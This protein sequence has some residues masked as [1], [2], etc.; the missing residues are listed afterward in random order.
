MKE[1][2]NLDKKLPAES[3]H[4]N[5]RVHG[6]QK[7]LDSC[8]NGPT[9]SR[10]EHKSWSISQKTENEATVKTNTKTVV[11]AEQPL[12][13]I[14]NRDL[15]AAKM[16]HS[17]C[18]KSKSEAFY[19]ADLRFGIHHQQ[20]ATVYTTHMPFR[21]AKAARG[22]AGSKNVLSHIDD[23]AGHSQLSTRRISRY[24]KKT[25]PLRCSAAPVLVEAV[26]KPVRQETNFAVS[27]GS[28]GH[29]CEKGNRRT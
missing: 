4:I 13:S 2:V 28:D 26:T 7:Q 11:R 12:H 16:D 25:T 9:G 21:N 15:Q 19:T 22:G 5:H 23:I 18:D 20:P 14:E 8:S 29:P 24:A 10:A 27:I 3:H 6:N 1:L 17:T